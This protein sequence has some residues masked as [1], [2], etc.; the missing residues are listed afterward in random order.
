MVS[1]E[2]ELSFSNS[3]DERFNDSPIAPK[4]KNLYTFLE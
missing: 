1:K 4:K 2:S 3:N